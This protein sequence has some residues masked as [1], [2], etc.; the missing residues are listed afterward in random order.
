M[1]RRRGG[2]LRHPQRQKRSS[3]HWW[4]AREVSADEKYGWARA[5]LAE[6]RW[7]GSYCRSC[8]GG[9]RRRT[10][11]GPGCARV[12]RNSPP[13]PSLE[14]PKPPRAA[15]RPRT[16]PSHLLPAPEPAL[17]TPGMWRP[18]LSAGP[19]PLSQPPLCA[20]D[21]RPQPAVAETHLALC[22]SKWGP[23]PPGGAGTPRPSSQPG[24]GGPAA[25]EQ[26]QPGQRA[27]SWV[28]LCG[29]AGT[30][31]VNT[32]ALE[33]GTVAGRWK[34][35]RL[36]RAQHRWKGKGASEPLWAGTAG[37]AKAAGQSGLASPRD[38]DG[39]AG[40][41]SEDVAGAQAAGTA[42]RGSDHCGRHGGEY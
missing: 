30:G 13:R 5:P 23:N 38:Q 27:K 20:A 17:G 19:A 21:P 14:G 37:S 4:G 33:S 29:A 7:L 32:P 16:A 34:R 6:M 9:R 26:E 41:V 42:W 24:W 11:T 35:P 10:E 31:L 8:C 25:W 36:P 1:R 22:T 15:F 18:S 28:G 12:Q 40:G 2:G 39:A 3:T